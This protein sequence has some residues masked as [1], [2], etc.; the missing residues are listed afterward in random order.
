MEQVRLRT[1]G[2][3]LLSVSVVLSLLSMG[4]PALVDHPLTTGRGGL[5]LYLDVVEEGNLPTWW[6]VGLLVTGALAHAVVAVAAWGTSRRI[7]L[8]WLGSAALLAMLS[9]DDHTSLHER[10][11]GLGRDLATV[12]GMHFYWVV[13]GLA[14]GAA[15][16]LGVSL[17]VRKLS[18][19]ARR[20]LML[21]CVLLLGAALGGEILQGML[22]DGGETGPRYVL[23]YHAEELGEN[24]GALLMLAAAGAALC[25]RRTADGVGLIYRGSGPSVTRPASDAPTETLQRVHS[26]P[27]GHA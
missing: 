25:V 10:M 7:G 14:I 27:V 21:G 1:V 18:G 8:A 6:S 23:T 3:A 5:R 13:P 19:P 11:D 4:V 22:L 2:V 20:Y 16:L 12:D 24:L 9:L 26:T 17:L 15:I